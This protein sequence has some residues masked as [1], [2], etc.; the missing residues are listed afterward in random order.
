MILV[1]CALQK[2]ISKDLEMEQ[3]AILHTTE[4]Q[5]LIYHDVKQGMSFIPSDTHNCDPLRSTICT[6]ALAKWNKIRF[7]PLLSTWLSFEYN[8]FMI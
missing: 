5:C 3:N 8:L 4:S 2:L 7:H 1:P 6:E